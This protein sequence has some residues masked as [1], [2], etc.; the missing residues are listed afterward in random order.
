MF[1][2]EADF[3][4][5]LATEL[6]ELG[7]TEIRLERPAPG[8]SGR[9]YVDIVAR[10]PDGVRWAIE[11]KYWTRKLELTL[12]DD[13][14]ELRDQSAHDLNRYAFCKDLARVQ[15]LVAEGVAQRGRVIALTND[16][17]YWKP[18]RSEQCLDAAFRIHEGRELSGVLDWTRESGTTKGKGPLALSSP[19]AL[20]WE[21][22]CELDGKRGRFRLLDVRIP[23]SA[24]PPG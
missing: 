3:Q 5:E 18:G 9:I 12:G 7:W 24:H 10:D 13:V 16:S 6:R 4:F 23:E 8:Q 11:L 14:F 19:V 2:S 22:F 15:R 21:D 17:A 20:A 1:H